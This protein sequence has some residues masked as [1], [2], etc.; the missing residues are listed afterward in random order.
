MEIPG[1]IHSRLGARAAPEDDSPVKIAGVY[2][3]APSHTLAMGVLRNVARNCSPTCKLHSDWWS[4]DMLEVAAE[5]E[6]AACAAAAADMIWWAANACEALPESVRRWAELW[7]AYRE[8]ECALVVLLR[9]PSD[10]AIE[11]SPSCAYLRWLAQET[12]AV[13]FTQRFECGCRRVAEPPPLPSFASGWFP[14]PS[15]P[16]RGYARWGINE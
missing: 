1:L 7:S 3:D 11:Q 2:A 15:E 13:L 5:R 16:E 6:A 10:Y 12:R 4:F 14:M 9:C 8:G